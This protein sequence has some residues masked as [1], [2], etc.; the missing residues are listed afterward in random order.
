MLAARAQTK[1]SRI[2]CFGEILFDVYSDY[3][4]LGGAPFNFAYHLHRF[5]QQVAFV[6][7]VGDDE[8]GREILATL[9]EQ[10]FPTDF[11]QV[12]P[13]HPTGTVNVRLDERGVPDFTIVEKVA[14]DFISTEGPVTNFI[15]S[16]VDLIYFGTLAQRNSASRTTLFQILEKLRNEAL[17]FCDVNLRQDFYTGSL[18]KMA[19]DYS[20]AI[21]LNEDELTVLKNLLGYDGEE[22]EAASKLMQS[23][24]IEHLCLTKGELGSSIYSASERAQWRTAEAGPSEIIDTVGAGDGYAAVLAYGLLERAPLADIAREASHFAE[25]LCGISGAIPD[26]HEFYLKHSISF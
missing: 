4:R 5:G 11:I 15:K 12:D 20:D 13:E 8:N 10:Q 3:K 25:A 18:L 26:G 16:G 6:S 1:A 22:S 19:L 21:K 2:L 14:Y 24:G 23:F 9:R 7:R 17:A